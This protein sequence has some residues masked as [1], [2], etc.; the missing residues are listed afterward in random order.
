MIE[1]ES[2]RLSAADA[3]LTDEVSQS[4]ARQQRTAM[5]ISRNL[6]RCLLDSTV[7]SSYNLSLWPSNTSAE[8]GNCGTENRER[9][10]PHERHCRGLDGRGS[11]YRANGFLGGRQRLL[12]LAVA[13]ST[14]IVLLPIL[15]VAA[16]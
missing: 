5:L 6:T 7:L 1:K 2:R 12:D 4:K 3:G 14:L 16:A 11:R 10:V 9:A 15:L 13:G 8:C